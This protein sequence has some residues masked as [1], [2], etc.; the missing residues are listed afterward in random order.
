MSVGFNVRLFVEWRRLSIFSGN[1]RLSGHEKGLLCYTAL[2][3]VSTMLMCLQQVVKGIAIVYG[4]TD[5]DLWVTMQ[6]F[7]INDVMISVPP[8]SLLMLSTDLRR[9]IFDFLRCSRHGVNTAASVTVFNK[10]K[11]VHVE[12]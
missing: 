1:S 11:T 5:L 10:R 9:D 2:V 4:Y 3:F 6:F 7:W 8:A 12:Y